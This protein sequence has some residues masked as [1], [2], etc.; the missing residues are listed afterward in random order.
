MSRFYQLSKIEHAVKRIPLWKKITSLH[1]NG[2][3]LLCLLFLGGFYLVQINGVAAKG[4]EIKHLENQR[5]ALKEKSEK[6]ELR[7]AELRSM[8]RIEEEIQH[9]DMVLV[10]GNTTY[11]SSLPSAVALNH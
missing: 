4:F 6:Q 3:L 2:V 5:D 8:S 1:I 9:M 7:M 10:Q 11:V